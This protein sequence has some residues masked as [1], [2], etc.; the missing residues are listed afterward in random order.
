MLQNPPANVGDAR[1]IPWLGRSPGNPLQYSC[2]GNPM[3]RE[4]WWAAVHGI[5][6]SDSKSQ[7]RL[8]H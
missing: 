1:S 6:Q 7:K 5:V 3:D 2:L 8:S 4:V